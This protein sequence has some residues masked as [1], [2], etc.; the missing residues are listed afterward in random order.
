MRAALAAS[1][2]K[3]R[4]PSSSVVT[5]T[6]LVG[7]KKNREFLIQSMR[8]VED[9]LL[10]EPSLPDKYRVPCNALS[11]SVFLWTCQ[12]LGVSTNISALQ[13]AKLNTVLGSAIAY[14]AAAC[15]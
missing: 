5:Y 15:R 6:H 1:S 3:T 2:S 9:A 8:E 14:A 4:Q 7:R 13:T 10:R 12:I 11:A